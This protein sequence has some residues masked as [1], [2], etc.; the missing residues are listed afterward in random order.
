MIFPRPK[1][2]GVSIVAVFFNMQREAER[3][4]YTLSRAYQQ[5]DEECR[6][7]V[8]AVDHGSTAPLSAEMVRSFGPEFS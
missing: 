6:Y 3:T 8:I 2:K 7:E 4:L 5:L 1:P